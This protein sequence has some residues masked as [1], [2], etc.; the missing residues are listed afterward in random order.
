M[1][2]LIPDE[3][4]GDIA[5]KRPKDLRKGVILKDNKNLLKGEVA[6]SETASFVLQIGRSIED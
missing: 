6:K 2:L 3:K 1:C 5:S 4:Y